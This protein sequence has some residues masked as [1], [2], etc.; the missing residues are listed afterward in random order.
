[1]GFSMVAKHAQGKAAQDKIFG[2]NDAAVKLAAQIGKDKVTNATI[3]AIL[4]ENEKLCCLPTVEKFYRALPT[5]ELVQYAGIAGLPDFLEAVIGEACG[6]SRPDAHM[7]A[8]AT[9]GG[10]GVLHHV[11]WNYASEGDKIL[12][13]DWYWGAYSSICRDMLRKLDT[14]KMFDENNKYNIAGLEAKTRELLATQESLVV[15]IN[16]PAHNP[17]GYTVSNEEWDDILARLQKVIKETGKKIILLVDMAYLDYA[18]EREEVRSFIKKFENLPPD[19][20]VVLAYSMSKG[21]T[22]YG[23]RTGAM[24]G[25]SSEESVIQEFKDVNQF[26]SRATWSNI[27]RPCMRTLVN[28]CKDPAAVAAIQKERDE[29]YQMIKKRADIFTAE[30]KAANLAMVPYIAGFFLSMDAK[31]PDAVCDKLHEDNIY[32]VPLA[33]GVRVAVCAVPVEKMKGM[34]AKIKKAFDAVEK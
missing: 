1:M 2:A 11:I 7:A 29:L 15:I 5:D 19:L 32:A 30:A 33:K 25:I 3:G 6:N 26:T 12:T 20:L 4:D 16:T 28:I 9:T 34:A 21:Y 17:T 23:Q 24:I 18:G 10:T 22:L 13:T 31:D 14:Y 8:V 27:N